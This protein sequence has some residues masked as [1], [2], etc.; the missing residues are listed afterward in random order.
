MKISVDLINGY[1]PDQFG[2]HA[3]KAYTSHDFPTRSFPINI[4]DIPIGT[5]ALALTLID[6]DAVPVA[7]FP[8]IH[9]I[10]TDI[11]A[12]NYIPENISIL[13]TGIVQGKNSSVS[14]Y[15]D[16]HDPAIEA[17]YL[18][19]KPPADHDYTLTV[20]AL[21]EKTGLKPGFYLNGLMRQTKERTI[22]KA[23]LEIPSRG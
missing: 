13:N 19:P 11:D 8:W 15:I 18:G 4:S 2:K 22:E 1:L 21:K 9:W 16:F 20:Y 6:Y 10:A 14:K 23:T 7:G 5:K 17:R 3:P 12:T